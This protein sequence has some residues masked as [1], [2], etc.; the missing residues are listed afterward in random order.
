MDTSY[1]TTKTYT[2][3]NE[4]PE[5]MILTRFFNGLWTAYDLGTIY[6]NWRE[7]GMKPRDII[8]DKCADALPNELLRQAL[9]DSYDI[10]HH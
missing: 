2:E 5:I 6:M 7:T 9:R 1:A 10:V 8:R 3:E 4:L